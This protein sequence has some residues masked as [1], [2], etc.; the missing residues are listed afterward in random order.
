MEARETVIDKILEKEPRP[1]FLTVL[2]ILSWVWIGFALLTA[3]LGL[4]SGP[5][6][7]EMMLEQTLQWTKLGDEL[8][9]VGAD[10]LVHMT[11]QMVRMMESLNANHYPNTIVTV[12]DLFIGLVGVIFMWQGRRLGFHLYIVYSILAIVQIYFFVAPSDIPTIGIVFNLLIAGLFIFLYA[13]NL[14]WME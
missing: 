5:A 4:I 6:S 3:F 11:E 7:E 14:K 1:S 9:S 10:G 2:C 12:L 13:R 8:R